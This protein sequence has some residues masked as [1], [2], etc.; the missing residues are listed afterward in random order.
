MARADTVVGHTRRIFKQQ[1]DTMG[2][3]E[4][5][6]DKGRAFRKA[7]MADVGE[8]I[9]ASDASKASAYNTVR[10]EF[11]RDN[12]IEQDLVGRKTKKEPTPEQAPST[13]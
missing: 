2:V 7:V 10:K 9:E 6:A 13:E 12:V 4:I 1:I 8:A 3:K 5:G 11:I